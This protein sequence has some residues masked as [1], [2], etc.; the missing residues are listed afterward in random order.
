MRNPIRYAATLLLTSGLA[1]SA[2]AA[3]PQS[4][5]WSNVPAKTITLF[6]PGQSTYD[7]LL[8]PAHTKGDK[9]VAQ[10]KACLSCHEGDEKDL[11]NKLVK[12]GALEPTPIP[13]KAGVVDVAVQAAHDAEFL[14]L[15]LQWKTRLNREGRMHDY[16]RFDGK[17]WKWYGGD[18]NEKEVRAGEQP[19]LYEDRLAIMIDDGK[20]P[21]FPQQGCWLTCHNGMRDT[22][23]SAV[24]DPVKKHP[25]LGDAGLKQTDV[26]KY[27]KSTRID[28]AA[29]WDKTKSREEIDKVKAAG[30]FLDLMQWRVAR[31]AAIGMADDGYVL[32]YRLADEGKD[33]FSWQ[34]NRSTMT[35]T[36]MFDAAK[37]GAKALRAEDIGNPAKPAAL[38]KETNAVPY[39]PNAGWKEGD[40]LPGRMLSRADA[41]GSAADN[42]AAFGTWKDGTYTLVWRRKLDT[43]HPADDKIMKVGGKYTVGIAVHDDNVTTRFHH[44][45][46]PL[47]L[48]IGVDADIKALT[49][50]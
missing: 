50:K 46:F 48:G 36:Y 6:Y 3:D 18:R 20:V 45:S 2:L 39:D 40:I 34:I 26:R 35:P 12:A 28:D 17:Q 19:P 10:G 33:P 9:Q 44:V 24:G 38:I 49:L 37:V 15:R 14:Y 23:N 8:S 16:V 5:Q 29:T 1:A 42:D 31:S 21:T 30:G 41:K 22:Q 11:G 32:E 25:L 47:S 43:G 27:L 4:I 13:D 7:W